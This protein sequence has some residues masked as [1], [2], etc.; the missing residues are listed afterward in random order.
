MKKT[1]L[2]LSLI[3]VSNVVNAKVS[4]EEANG[5]ILTGAD[6]KT[7]YCLS[8]PNMSWWSAFAWCDAI[9]NA[10]IVDITIECNKKLAD[11]FACP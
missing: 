2:I 6:G 4:C 5:Y 8:K 1:L 7:Q 10:S 9:E 3:V 11:G